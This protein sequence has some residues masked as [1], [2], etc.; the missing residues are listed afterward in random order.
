MPDAQTSSATS[1]EMSALPK[2][3]LHAHLN[4]SVP[5]RLVRELGGRD[6]EY[7]TSTPVPNLEAY[8]KPWALAR[9]LASSRENLTRLVDGVARALVEDGVRYAELRNSVRHLGG[10]N[11]I[12][13]TESIA[14]LLDSFDEASDRESID[15]RLIVTL[16]REGF[17]NELA[18]RMLDACRPLVHH[19]RLVGL[20]LAGDETLPLPDKASTVFRRAADEL[21]FGIT[22]HAGEV[23]GTSANILWALDSCRALRLGHA[24]AA[25]EDERVLERLRSSSACVEVCLTSNRLTSSVPDLHNH[26]VKIFLERGVDFVLCSDNP[27]MHDRYL[28]EE[29]VTFV[30]LIGSPE[31]LDGMYERQMRFSFA[32]RP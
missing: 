15:L 14:W 10:L 29:Y 22:I 9:R 20:D 16:T 3:E 28:T 12:H 19:P 26:P 2:A 30:E 6:E 18:H 13:W 25:T 27:G 31:H 24:I 4:G 23:S 7:I 5:V 32:D 11:D 8:F 17:D 21:G 1:G